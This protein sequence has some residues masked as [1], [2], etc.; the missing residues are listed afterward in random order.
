MMRFE[1]RARTRTAAR[2][3]RRHAVDARDGAEREDVLVR[4]PVA[5]DADRLHRQQ[6][7]ERLPDLVVEAA[8]AQLVEPDRVGLPQHGEGGGRDGAE[9]ADGEAGTGERVAPDDPLGHAEEPSN[10]AHL[11]LE[12]LPERFEE[13][14]NRASPAARRRCGGS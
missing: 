14:G 11:V 3:V 13:L 10:L 8:R 5:H 12:Q 1:T 4:P 2:P 7:R 9:D 6:H